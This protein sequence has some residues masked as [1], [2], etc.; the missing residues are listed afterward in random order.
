MTDSIPELPFIKDQQLTDLLRTI[1][2]FQ[3]RMK[4]PDLM[5]ASY[6]EACEILQD[7]FPEFSKNYNSIFLMLMRGDKY[8]ALATV[9][10][11]RSKVANG[12]MQEEKLANMVADKYIPKELRA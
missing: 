4:E 8:D 12:E 10:Y 1:K 9:L 3:W 5:S 7:E 2:Q 11:Y 6:A